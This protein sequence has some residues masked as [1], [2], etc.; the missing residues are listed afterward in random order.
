ML[1]VKINGKEVQVPEGSTIM[2]AAHAANVK[3]PSLCYNKDL[4]AWGSCGLCVVH[5]ENNNRMMRACC[6]KAVDGMSIITHD[7]E[8]VKARRSVLELIL[9]N[10]PQECLTC[11]RN[12]KCELQSLAAEFGLRDVHFE[13]FLNKKPKDESN[14]SI[15]FDRNKCISCGRCVEVCQNMQAVHA[16]EYQGRG[17][18]TLIAP[19]AMALLKDSPCVRCGQCAAHCPVG[20]IYEATPKVDLWSKLL[21]PEI[22]SVVQIAPS[23]RVALGEEFG[24]NPGELTTGKIYTALRRIGF[25]YVFDTNFSA[26]LTI[27]EEA[28]EFV[29]NFTNKTYKFPQFTSCCPSWVDFAEKYH[30][31]LI[32]HLS[33]TKSPMQIM[34]AMIKTYWAEKMKIDPSKI[35]SVAVMPCTS[36]KY[37]CERNADMFVSGYQDVDT[38]ITTREF[39]N[40][41]RQSG[42]EFNILEEQEADAP[43]GP[44]SGAGTIFG[45]TGGVMEA[46]LR[47]AYFYITG[48]ELESLDFNAARGLDGVKEAKINIQGKEVRIAV[49]NQLGNLTGFLE[50]VKESIRLG[51]EPLYHFIEVMACRGGCVGGGGQPYGCTDEVR[52]KR[53]QGLYKDDAESK[54][55]TSHG[56]PYIQQVYREFLDKPNSKKAHKLLHT[57]YEERPL[58]KL[59]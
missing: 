25:E 32:P 44:Y 12:N 39:A 30:K 13:R 11:S 21:D 6:T 23:V 2:E 15:V 49:V 8:I 29:N 14:S 27:T 34:G 47:T 3:I 19:A 37:E 56:N 33:S 9:S 24:L 52:K 18:K 10:H 16:I 7:P 22:I 54:V 50:K 35:F 48:R 17:G 36:K 38:V 5:L 51:G 53:A 4:P 42:I 28:Q 58:Y 40:Y 43:L 57:H 31:D 1:N 45:A 20:A 46:A 41:I 59:N 26:D 55:R